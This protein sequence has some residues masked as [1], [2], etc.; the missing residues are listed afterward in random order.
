MISAAL[1]SITINTS[2]G[3]LGNKFHTTIDL[4][5]D[6]RDTKWLLLWHLSGMMIWTRINFNGNQRM[7]VPLSNSAILGDIILCPS[8]HPSNPSPL[9]RNQKCVSIWVLLSCTIACIGIQA[10]I[11]R[12]D[13]NVNRESNQLQPMCSLSACVITCYRLHFRKCS[14][15]CQEYIYQE[16]IRYA[17]ASGKRTKVHMDINIVCSLRWMHYN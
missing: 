2:C 16:L 3:Y 6:K 4:L 11:T 12:I 8:I 7:H 10:A 15:E 17:P 14:S 1:L 5:P 9:N 13:L